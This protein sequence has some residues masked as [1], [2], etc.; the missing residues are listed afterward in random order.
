ELGV[1]LVSVGKGPP[2]LRVLGFKRD[3]RVVARDVQQV[4]DSKIADGRLAL[5]CRDGRQTLQVVLSKAQPAQLELV[6]R[7]LRGGGAAGA[8]SAASAGGG[9]P[10]QKRARTIATPARGA[11][12]GSAGPSAEATKAAAGLEAAAGP[13]PRASA[14]ISLCDFSEEVLRLV[15]SFEAPG[16]LQRLW[17]ACSLLDVFARA[18]QPAFRLMPSRGAAVPPDLVIQRV[19]RHTMIRELDLCGYQDLPASATKPLADALGGGGGGGLRKLCLRGCKALTDAAVRRL[20]LSCPRLEVLDLL[21]V[22]RLSDQALQAPLGEL[23]MLLVGTLGRPQVA[24]ESASEQSR[25]RL[26]GTVVALGSCAPGPQQ[27]RQQRVLG[28]CDFTSALLARLA[29]PPAGPASAAG[30]PREGAGAAPV[31]GCPLLEH[32]VFAHCAEVRVLPRLSATLRHLDLRGASLQLPAAAAESWRPLAGCRQ[33]AVLNLAHNALLGASAIAACVGSRVRMWPP[34]SALDLSDTSADSGLLAALPAKQPRLSH[35]RASGCR[36]LSDEVLAAWLGG[37]AWLQVLDVSHCDALDEPFA[38][39]AAAPAGADAPA[40]A[41]RLRLLGVGGTRLATCIE[42]TRRALGRVAP[43]AVARTTALDL[44]D[45]YR[46]LPPTLCGDGGG[47]AQVAPSGA[48]PD[49]AAAAGGAG[50]ARRASA[51]ARAGS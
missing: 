34:M 19:A 18:R 2:L 9:A 27:P 28:T 24:V 49:A 32:V 44:F 14:A 33:L 11:P 20:L 7:S 31:G 15:V 26:I 43:G 50:G 47:A 3:I 46:L 8:Q 35:L 40:P 22:P 21:E 36:G 5:Q 39:V 25:K 1:Q 17:E 6:L 51:W 37:L 23:R 45:G 10:P 38:L 16:R 12:A 13:G 41:P 4:V 48:A 30:G 42:E 29:R